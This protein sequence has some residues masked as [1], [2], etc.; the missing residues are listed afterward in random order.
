MNRNDFKKGQTVYLKYIGDRRYGNYGKIIEATVKSVGCKYITTVHES[1]NEEHKFEV[2]N[3]FREY[4]KIGGRDY[5]LF[6]SQQCI[7][8]ENEFDM[9]QDFLRNTFDR[10]K[11]VKLSLDQL[12]R[13]KEIVDE[14]K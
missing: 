14:G 7:D 6:L 11:K 2:D 5:Q 12:R 13:I 8:E 3:D 10:Y 9:I 1:W 4:Y